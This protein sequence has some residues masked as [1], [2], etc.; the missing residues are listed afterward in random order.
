L[1]AAAGNIVNDIYDIESDKISHPNRVLVLGKLNKTEVKLEYIILNFISAIISINL[2]QI[3][4][5]IV[6]ISA[7]LL[8]IYSAYLKKFR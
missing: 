5:A 1:V 7:L 2:S 3:L 8:F 6:F 4:F